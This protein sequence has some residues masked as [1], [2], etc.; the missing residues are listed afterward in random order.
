[1][2]CR[3]ALG[4]IRTFVRQFGGDGCACAKPQADQPL[5][6][7]RSAIARRKTRTIID[8]GEQDCLFKL[9]ADRCIGS[10]GSASDATLADCYQIEGLAWDALLNE[11]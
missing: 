8:K 7:R 9:V 5:K 4:G 6:S 11:N 2:A 10:P 3:I 1:M